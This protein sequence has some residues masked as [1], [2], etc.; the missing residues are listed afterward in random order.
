MIQAFVVLPEETS[1]HYTTH[2]IQQIEDHFCIANFFPAIFSDILIT[3]LSNNTSKS[4]WGAEGI[5]AG[6]GNG[7]GSKGERGELHGCVL[8]FVLNTRFCLLCYRVLSCWSSQ[9]KALKQ[10]AC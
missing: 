2:V 4:V 3:H 8:K 9:G 5:D 10:I 1:M 6:S 7:N